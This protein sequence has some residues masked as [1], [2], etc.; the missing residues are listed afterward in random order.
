MP[1]Q[2]S[3]YSNAEYRERR[4]RL[5]RLR[6]IGIEIGDA[7]DFPRHASR[8]EVEQIDPEY[9]AIFELPLGRAA[10]IVMA[11][12]TVV[13]SGV[14]ITQTRM[15]IPWG[16]DLAVMDPEACTDARDCLEA[17]RFWPLNSLS[18]LFAQPHPLLRRREEGLIFAIGQAEIPAECRE[19]TDVNLA[20]MLTDEQG[21]DSVHEFVTALDRSILRKYRSKPR[22]TG[23][24]RPIFEAPEAQG[25]PDGPSPEKR[26]GNQPLAAK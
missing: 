5:L 21:N 11:R 18:K 10:V 14:L 22:S 13:T 6:E 2:K 1:K 8:F 23:K 4:S 17:L 24:R 16:S 25:E 9:A 26:L 3:S 20:L 12:V 19:G 15:T 7:D